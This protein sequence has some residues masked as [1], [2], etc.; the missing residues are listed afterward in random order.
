MITHRSVS[1]LGVANNMLVLLFLP[2]SLAGTLYKETLPSVILLPGG[3]VCIG[4]AG[5]ILDF[6]L[7]S[8]QFL[9]EFVGISPR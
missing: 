7:L 1:S 5:P 8:C 6:P 4:K 2:P 9:G 3:W